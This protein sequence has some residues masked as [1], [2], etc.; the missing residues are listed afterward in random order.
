MSCRK[1]EISQK[2]HDGLREITPKGETFDYAISFLIDYYLE[3]EEFY[4][5]EAEYYN[6]KAQGYLREAEY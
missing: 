4:D 3:N 6:K 1:I 2:V 5:D